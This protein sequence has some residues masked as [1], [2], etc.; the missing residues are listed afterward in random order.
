MGLSEAVA[1]PAPDTLHSNSTEA[2]KTNSITRVE[3]LHGCDRFS[4]NLFIMCH[5]Q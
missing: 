2:Q 3:S 5:I 1:K 4:G